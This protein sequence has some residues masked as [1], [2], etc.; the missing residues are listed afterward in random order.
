[1]K[2]TKITSMA[3]SDEQGFGAHYVKIDTDVGIYGLGE[4][5]RT[6]W[7]EAIGRAIDHLGE[8]VIGQDPFATERVW[9]HMFRGNFSLR[10]GCMLLLSAPLIL[11]CGISRVRPLICRSISY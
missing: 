6:V 7:G 8:I 10:M 3:L 1:M 11:L 2:V 9:Q 4:V 5:G